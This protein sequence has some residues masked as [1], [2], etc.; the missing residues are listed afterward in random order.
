MSFATSEART[1]AIALILKLTAPD[2]RTSVEA[3][4][5]GLVSNA[6]TSGLSDGM[7]KAAELIGN[8][9]ASA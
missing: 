3:L 2:V 7:Q 8:I 5:E 4:L 6:Y 9:Q 1:E